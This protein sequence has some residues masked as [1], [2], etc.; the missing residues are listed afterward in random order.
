[1]N[2]TK[3]NSAADSKALPKSYYHTITKENYF[4]NQTHFKAFNKEDEYNEYMKN[5]VYENKDKLYLFSEENWNSRTRK[6]FPIDHESIYLFSKDKKSH[7]FEHFDR[8]EKIKLYLDIDLK[9]KHIPKE[10]NLKV[11]F[12][13]LIYECIK[14]V[15]DELEKYVLVN[16]YSLCLA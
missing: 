4:K 10:G 3:A 11:F 14:T 12:D 2:N 8:D 1:M 16:S 13:N 6:F 7:L 9:E 15:T 5:L